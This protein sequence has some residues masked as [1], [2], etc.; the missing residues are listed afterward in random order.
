MIM[1]PSEPV[2][3][4]VADVRDV[5]NEPLHVGPAGA[6]KPTVEDVFAPA[7]VLGDNDG[8]AGPEDRDAFGVDLLAGEEESGCWIA[9]AVVCFVVFEADSVVLEGFLVDVQAQLG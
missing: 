5:H 2:A 3:L 1:N 8:S 4:E 9:A 6:R 7:R